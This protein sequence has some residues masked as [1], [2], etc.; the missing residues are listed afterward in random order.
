MGDQLRL[1]RLTA[2]EVEIKARQLSDSFKHLQA[3]G[4]A[5]KV[6]KD[7]LNH[8]PEAEKVKEIND[9]IASTRE[10]ANKLLSELGEESIPEKAAEY[11]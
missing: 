8:T 1:F 3:L 2:L 10:T 5:R 4:E 7:L 11:A 9:E 6:A